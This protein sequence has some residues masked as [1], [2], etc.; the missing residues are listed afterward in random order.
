MTYELIPTGDAAQQRV[1]RDLAC[2][3][4][5]ATTVRYACKQDQFPS[6]WAFDADTGNY[7]VGLMHEEIRPENLAERYAFACGGAMFDVQLENMFGATLKI[8]P[9]CGAVIEDVRAFREEL[10]RAFAVHGRYGRPDV[11]SP[12]L[13]EFGN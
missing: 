1:L 13:P 10:T 12:L 9:V 4:E 8:T 6:H 11:P 7:L 3:Q 2:S 5:H